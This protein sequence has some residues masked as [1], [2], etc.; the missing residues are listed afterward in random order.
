MSLHRIIRETAKTVLLVLLLMTFINNSK[1]LYG[2]DSNI[3]INFET[4][5]DGSPIPEGTIL[6][7]QFAEL[8]VL[9]EV[10]ADIVSSRVLVIEDATNIDVSFPG[11]FS[12]LTPPNA[13]N[14]IDE[15]DITPGP[16][17]GVGCN[18]DLRME[19]V[20]G[21]VE[22]VSILMFAEAFDL[23]K[24]VRLVAKD[25]D[26]GTITQDEVEVI[27]DGFRPYTFNIS[28]PGIASVETEGI[29]GGNVC[30]IYDNLEFSARG[31]VGP[32]VIIP[33]M[34]QWGMIIATVLIGF[35]AIAALRKRTV[36]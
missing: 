9:F 13:L 3:V 2:A 21:T 31:P 7:D 17:S 14:I 18:W 30:A 5:P 15:Q 24:T 16:I 11:D 28:A 26:G 22:S 6:T 25:L 23:I 12:G 27:V 20:S 32:V 34:G 35:F 1:V 36:S 4:F 19:F 33:T 10:A 29:T 8:G